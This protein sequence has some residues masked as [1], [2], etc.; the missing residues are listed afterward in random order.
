MKT[1]F[2]VVVGGLA[3][4]L[5]GC[6][7]PERGAPEEVG[8]IADLPAE[9]AH[10]ASS[11]F[12]AHWGDGH[13][14][15]STYRG[16]LAR[17]GE[18][19]DARA[20]LIFVT[21]P[22]D[23]R[24]WIKSP[25]VDAPHRVE[26][27]KLNHL[28]TFQTGV[29]PYH[30]MRSV[31]AP[32]DRWDG[33]RTGF[34]PVKIALSVQEWCGQVSH[35]LWPGAGEYLSRLSSYFESEGDV[36]ERVEVEAGTLYADALPIQVRELDGPF[37]E[38]AERW[39][40]PLIPTLWQARVEHQPLQVALATITRSTVERQGLPYTRFDVSWPGGAHYFEVEQHYPRRIQR[41]GS[42]EG[43]AFERVATER[44]P[45]WQLNSLPDKA[46]RETLQLPLDVVSPVRVPAPPAVPAPPE[47][48]PTGTPPAF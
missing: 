15:I 19:R 33:E 47:T 18:L 13:G 1:R 27:L 2:C 4:G 39:T 10:R 23:K 42:S 17:Y 16:T 11:D 34:S 8:S 24:T 30:V 28:V 38:G 37:L 5:S 35:I 31:F 14:E 26:V 41:F 36:E 32:V 3:L 6:T 48:P 43:T 46:H 29:Y 25:G 21:E 12:W 7:A 44:L 45:Y 22:H 9:P 40:G 20:T